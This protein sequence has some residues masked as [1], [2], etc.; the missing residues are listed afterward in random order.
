MINKNS[1]RK[2]IQGAFQKKQNRISA[3]PGQLGDGAGEV[4]VTG[5]LGYVYCR[6]S[7]TVAEVFN[8][9]VPAENN[10]LVMVGYDPAQPD[11]FQ[12]LTTRTATP[13][14]TS[15]G[16]IT[17]FAPAA[18]YRWMANGGGQ[19]PLYVEKRA[20]L[21]LRIGPLFQMTIMIYRD[22]MWTGTVWA[23]VDT[24]NVNLEAHIP[25]TANKAALVLITVSDA[26][27]V[28]TTKGSE[29]NIDALLLTDIPAVPAGTREVLGAVRVYYG[30]LS[31]RESRTNTD[32]V[33]LRGSWSPSSGG[34]GAFTDLTDAPASYTGSGGKLVAVTDAEDGL[35]FITAPTGGG[36]GG[37]DTLLLNYEPTTDILAMTDTTSGVWYDV[38][39]DQNFTVTDDTKNIVLDMSGMMFGDTS[40]NSDVITEVIIDSTTQIRIGGTMNNAGFY[41]ANP[42]AGCGK[43]IIGALATGSHTIRV[44]ASTLSSAGRLRCIIATGV[45]F[46]RLYVWQGG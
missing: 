39:P 43:T 13:G 23:F 35:E 19:D 33:D 12:V 24:Q 11:L 15:L 41:S 14:G 8:N 46:L 5:R 37:G 16:A 36:G 21:P 26:G 25:T 38:C 4:N 31:I 32:I 34:G 28:V 9:R 6:M 40:G 42:L 22:V 17:G 45:D 18:R 30:Q 7:G 29:V 3:S 44:R 10:L 27:L 20:Y 2:L 1:L